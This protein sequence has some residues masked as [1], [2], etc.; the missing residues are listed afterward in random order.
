VQRN[1]QTS[2]RGA[3]NE[4]SAT[5]APEDERIEGLE[6]AL[7]SSGLKLDEAVPLIADLLQL[8]VGDRYPE[9]K[10]TPEE[11]ADGFCRR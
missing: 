1:E 2:L 9:L 8:P 4:E 5:F 10:L 11:G 3:H 7:A 6:R